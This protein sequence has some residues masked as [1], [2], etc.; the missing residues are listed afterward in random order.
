[1]DPKMDSGYLEPGDT[2]DDDYDACKSLEPKEL[3]GIMDQLLCNEVC[4]SYLESLCMKGSVEVG[5][6]AHGTSF[7]TD[8]VHLGLHRS[9][10]MA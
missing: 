6:L 8:L 1:M 10:I 3:L 7:V 9:I 4:S 5:R 2:L